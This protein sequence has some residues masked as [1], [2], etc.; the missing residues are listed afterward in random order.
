MRLAGRDQNALSFDAQD[1]LSDASRGADARLLTATPAWWTGRCGKLWRSPP[2][3]PARCW[4]RF[5]EWRSRLSTTD[6][7]V[8]RDRVLLRGHKPP[9]DLSLFE[10][11]A[12]HGLRLAPDTIDRLQG[13]APEAN[14]DDWK[15]LLSLPKASAGLRAMQEAER[16][17]RR[18]P[19]MAQHRMPGGA[20]LLSSL[21]GG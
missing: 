2:R 14:W 5:H 13:F 8:S 6:F 9:Q 16:A 15:R 20:R 17:C 11:V 21:H 19:G 18:A 7:T 4:R 10:F 1:S 3:R 12:R